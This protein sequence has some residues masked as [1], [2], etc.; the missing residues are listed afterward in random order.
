MN[1][2]SEGLGWF[3]IESLQWNNDQAYNPESL[4][5]S[6][7]ISMG[8]SSCWNQ[9]WMVTVGRWRS[10]WSSRL[11]GRL[12]SIITLYI[13]SY[14]C[15]G[16]IYYSPWYHSSH[17]RPSRA[18]PPQLSLTARHSNSQ[19][20][21][22]HHSYPLLPNTFVACVSCMHITHLSTLCL[23]QSLWGCHFPLWY[24]AQSCQLSFIFL[25]TCPNNVPSPFS[26]SHMYFYA[27]KASYFK[28]V[29]CI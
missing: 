1:Q 24:N 25:P 26:L 2:S 20:E 17:R 8:Y 14:T 29:V 7:W 19:S 16:K 10:P 22:S 11:L 21:P 12:H 6:D 18:F 23:W 15:L 5:Q 28:G 3:P 13:Y 4:A 27:L 9:V